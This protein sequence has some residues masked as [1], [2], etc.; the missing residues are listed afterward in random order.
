MTGALWEHPQQGQGE[1][2]GE[3][4]LS[5]LGS[6]VRKPQVCLCVYVYLCKYLRILIC[7]CINVCINVVPL[8]VCV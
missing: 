6:C 3:G 2:G 8:C 5:P 7:L 1:G 4:A